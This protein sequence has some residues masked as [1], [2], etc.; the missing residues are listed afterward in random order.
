MVARQAPLSMEFSRQEC[1]SGLPLATHSRRSSRP[2]DRA[3]SLGSWQEDSGPPAPSRTSEITRSGARRMCK[4]GKNVPFPE[5]AALLRNTQL[6]EWGCVSLTPQ[7]GVLGRAHATCPSWTAVLCRPASIG[8]APKELAFCRISVPKGTMGSKEQ[9]SNFTDRETEAQ[10]RRINTEAVC[11]RI[12]KKLHSDSLRFLPHPIMEVR[13]GANA[14]KLQIQK[15][16]VPQS[17]FRGR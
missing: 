13:V 10:G 17:R 15:R 6:G 16:V 12:G 7:V 3:L 4:S 5:K 1:W 11:G 14:S 2:E 8:F 9:P